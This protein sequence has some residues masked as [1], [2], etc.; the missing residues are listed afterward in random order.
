MID[1]YPNIISP[2]LFLQVNVN[3]SADSVAVE[4]EYERSKQLGEAIAAAVQSEIVNQQR[5]GGLLYG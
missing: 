5:A 2:L 3:V 4:S 1:E